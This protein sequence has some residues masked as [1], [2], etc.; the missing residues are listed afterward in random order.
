MKIHLYQ[1]VVVAISAIML[2][3]GT[4]E[5]INRE[6][7]QTVL[8][9]LVRLAEWGGMSFI[10]IY[11]DFTYYLSGIIGIEDNITAVIVTGFLF[12][13]LIIFKLMS[14]IEKI[15]QNISE[16]IRREALENAR[17]QIEEQ[18]KKLGANNND[19][20]GIRSSE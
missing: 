7:G 20:Q 13:F 8:K 11:P 10:V 4:K 15:E 17:D 5:F 2:F 9:S 18:K 1:I 3:Q 14:A 19:Q 12:V 16:L 6:T